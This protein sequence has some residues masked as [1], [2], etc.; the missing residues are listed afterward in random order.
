MCINYCLTSCIWLFIVHLLS[1]I[2]FIPQKW[3]KCLHFTFLFQIPLYFFPSLGD[4]FLCGIRNYQI[5]D[6]WFRT[7]D[8]ILWNICVC[9]CFHLYYCWCQLLIF[10]K[11]FQSAVTAVIMRSGLS[12][13][14]KLTTSQHG[15]FS[16]KINSSS[17]RCA[18]C[19]T[20]PSGINLC[21]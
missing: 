9:V 18:T 3:E 12:W 11:K 8:L 13:N 5:S 14:S 16:W 4:C 10:S 2:Q 15:L 6:Y 1:W 19:I 21:I 7:Y 20:P 17:G